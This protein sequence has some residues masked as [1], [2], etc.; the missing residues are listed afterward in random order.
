VDLD[1]LADTNP[2]LYKKILKECRENGIDPSLGTID[3][4]LLKG[5][6]NNMTSEEKRMIQN[7][8]LNDQASTKV[9]IEKLQ[10]SNP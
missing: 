3:E 1:R 6:M 8:S 5:L 9:D 4:S 7:C 2:T 10:E